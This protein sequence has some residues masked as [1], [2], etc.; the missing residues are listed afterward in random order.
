MMKGKIHYI[1]SE[2]V[3]NEEVK[4]LLK[5]KGIKDGTKTN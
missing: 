1:G 4:P 5:T 3:E 2:P